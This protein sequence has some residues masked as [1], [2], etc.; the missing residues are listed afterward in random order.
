MSDLVIHVIFFFCTKETAYEMRISDWRSDVC[1]SDSAARAA[2]SRRRRRAGI[3]RKYTNGLHAL[4]SL[5]DLEEYRGPLFNALVTGLP[6]AGKMQED[7]TGI[8]VGTDETKTFDCVE[9]FNLAGNFD[10]FRVA[11]AP[12]IHSRNPSYCRT[13]A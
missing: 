9:P 6:Q 13:G 3:D 1:S 8:V 5:G 7:V 2:R 12:L 10:D 11:E 4:G